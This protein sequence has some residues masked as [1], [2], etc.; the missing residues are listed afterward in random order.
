MMLV[1]MMM[2]MMM[3]TPRTMILIVSFITHVLDQVRE[4]SVETLSSLG[5]QQDEQFVDVQHP[6]SVLSR[7]QVV[8][9][10]ENCW[11][12]NLLFRDLWLEVSSQ[13]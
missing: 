11:P 8:N 7:V 9:C 13:T 3:V 12:K 1:I 4:P 6:Q 5:G 2:I 10:L